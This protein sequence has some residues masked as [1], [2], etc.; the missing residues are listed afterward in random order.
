MRENQV[1]ICEADG[2]VIRKAFADDLNYPRKL[3]VVFTDGTFALIR[4]SRDWDGD[5]ELQLSGSFD[6]SDF[7]ERN[8]LSAGII[9]PQWIE[10]RNAQQEK[11]AKLD[12]EIRAAAERAQYERLKAKFEGSK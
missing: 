3:V 5:V 9:T 7:S 4:H 8:L 12:R 6:E 10:E 2:K 11:R 1:D